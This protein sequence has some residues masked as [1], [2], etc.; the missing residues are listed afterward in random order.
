M[1]GAVNAF[2]L[3]RADLASHDRAGELPAG[4]A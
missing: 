4:M 1:P 2:L 3:G